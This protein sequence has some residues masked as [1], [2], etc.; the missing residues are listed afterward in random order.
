LHIGQLIKQERQPGRSN[1]INIEDPRDVVTD[2]GVIRPPRF[3]SL[4]RSVLSA[5]GYLVSPVCAAT[6]TSKS[7]PRFDA[8]EAAGDVSSATGQHSTTRFLP[9]VASA[10]HVIGVSSCR[11]YF[12]RATAHSRVSTIGFIGSSGPR[13]SKSQNHAGRNNHKD[14]IMLRNEFRW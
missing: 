11:P 3:H 14:G 2:S 9:V 5:S 7:S 8:V 12:P 1:T 6:M 4:P 10:L 13:G